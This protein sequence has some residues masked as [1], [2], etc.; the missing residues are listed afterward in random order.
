[1]KHSL[2]RSSFPI[3]AA[4]ALA[5]L[6]CGTGSVYGVWQL[7]WSDEFDGTSISTTNWTFEI[8]NTIGWG[9]QERE[10]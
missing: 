5:T 8:G 10:Y 4:L 2:F 7:V 3:A 6:T 1:V 9:N